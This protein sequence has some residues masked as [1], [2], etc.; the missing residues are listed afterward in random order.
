MVA[1]LRGAGQPDLRLGLELEAGGE[2]GVGEQPGA[3]ARLGDPQGL[4]GAGE[5]AVGGEHGPHLAAKAGGVHVAQREQEALA[6]F[7]G[8][9]HA[10]S[11]PGGALA[12]GGEWA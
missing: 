5:L 4:G 12:R 2:R 8:Q 1:G 11:I 9:G 6:I 7:G 10:V 3:Q